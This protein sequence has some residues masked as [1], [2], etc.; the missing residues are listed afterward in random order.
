[1][2]PASSTTFDPYHK[3]L[4]IP[5]SEQPPNSYRL[6]GL[7]LYEDDAEVIAAAAD[8]QMAHV[9][10]FAT[11]QNS[12]VSQQ[13]LNEL[14]RARVT[15]LNVRQKQS[16]DEQLRRALQPRSAMKAAAA[17]V[18]SRPDPWEADSEPSVDIDWPQL[19]RQTASTTQ[20]FKRRRRNPMGLVLLVLA[21][22][23]LAGGLL[24]STLGQR[25]DNVQPQ[26][27]AVPPRPA[28]R[29]IATTT[30]PAKRRQEADG[31]TKTVPATRPA[32]AAPQDETQDPAANNDGNDENGDRAKA[33]PMD[34]KVVAHSIDINLASRIQR[35]ELSV[36]STGQIVV[37]SL[38]GCKEPSSITPA[39]GVLDKN[40]KVTIAVK[41]PREV[42]CELSL[43]E[44][45]SENKSI[46][47]RY[48]VYNDEGNELPFTL[49]TMERVCRDISKEGRSAVAAFNS[50]D[51]ELGRLQRWIASPITKP[52]ADVGVAKARVLEL[53]AMAS[54]QSG[55]IETLEADL[56]VAES[57]SDFAKHLNDDCAISVKLTQ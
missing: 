45:D 42:Y 50:M 49:A 11:G 34:A 39:G 28:R 47:V 17:Q 44:Q 46:L 7:A 20:I 51:S 52:L 12:A 35:Y 43:R 53:N 15:L 55:L 19:R 2:R 16:Y 5:P 4:G 37:A 31:D 22:I 14:A 9:K 36:E 29:T 26:L 1:M 48:Y 40:T 57:M 13:L 18:L 21:L 38:E 32:V 24:F 54:D 41:G 3:W 8:R 33:L 25:A 27:T 56:E 23:C 30:Q 10:C 6:L